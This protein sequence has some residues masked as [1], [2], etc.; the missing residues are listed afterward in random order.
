VNADT[1]TIASTSSTDNAGLKR[2]VLP[3]SVSGSGAAAR[4]EGVRQQATTTPNRTEIGAGSP[5]PC[6][7]SPSSRSTRR[8]TCRRRISPGGHAREVDTAD[9]SAGDERLWRHRE[10]G[11]ERVVEHAAGLPLPRLC[12][13]HGFRSCRRCGRRRPPLTGSRP[14]RGAVV[15][16]DAGLSSAF[17]RQPRAAG[18]TRAGRSGGSRDL[19][20]SGLPARRVRARIGLILGRGTKPRCGR[21]RRGPRA[22]PCGEDRGPGPARLAPR[23]TP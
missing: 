22:R 10:S 2:Y 18:T 15:W 23:E 20:G 3:G 1:V 17:G 13:S 9:Q 5:T 7:R 12:G 6:T 19:Q 16:A 11:L 14:R 4:G 21:P 8:A